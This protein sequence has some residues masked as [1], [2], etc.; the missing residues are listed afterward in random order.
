MPSEITKNARWY[1]ALTLVIRVS[2]T[3]SINVAIA[4]KK[5]PA[6]VKAPETLRNGG[7]SFQSGRQT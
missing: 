6:Y 1:Q 5:M 2:R 7:P 3:S 4:T